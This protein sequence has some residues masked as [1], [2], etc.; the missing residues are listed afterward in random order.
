MSTLA[1]HQL[2]RLIFKL[3]IKGLSPP[4]LKNVVKKHD[5]GIRNRG[6]SLLNAA[7]YNSESVGAKVAESERVNAIIASFSRQV[8]LEDSTILDSIFNLATE[9]KYFFRFRES[10]LGCCRRANR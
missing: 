2:S 3:G 7:L 8:N 1:E 5:A 4:A 6:A 10:P 9:K